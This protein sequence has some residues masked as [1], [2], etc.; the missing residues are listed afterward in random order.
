MIISDAEY[1]EANKRLH[2]RLFEKTVIRF[3]TKWRI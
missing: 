2:R 3:Q 1:E